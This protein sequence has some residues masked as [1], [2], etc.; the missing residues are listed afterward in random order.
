MNFFIENPYPS[1]EKT[2]WVNWSV[3]RPF[4]ERNTVHPL[5]LKN[6]KH[7]YHCLWFRQ[8]GGQNFFVVGNIDYCADENCIQF[9][10]GRNRT[11]LLSLYL[12]NVPVS[13]QPS[14]FESKELV[15]G[16][17]REIKRT[18]VAVFPQLPILSYEQLMKKEQ[19]RI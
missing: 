1:N 4:F 9:S 17:I 16:I 12:E 5:D 8:K 6:L 19:A 10:N 14:V 15:K 7:A 3:F 13:L 18:E 2:Y 11:T